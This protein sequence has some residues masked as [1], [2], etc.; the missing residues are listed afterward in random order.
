MIALE[1]LAE[2]LHKKKVD[3]S[4]LSKI[5]VEDIQKASEWM[6]SDI[7]DGIRKVGFATT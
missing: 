6:L 7:V 4:K 1:K 2:K 3:D 5:L